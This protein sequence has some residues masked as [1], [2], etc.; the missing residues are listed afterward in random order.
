MIPPPC[1]NEFL[2][3]CHIELFLKLPDFIQFLLGVMNHVAG[4][5]DLI[6]IYHHSCIITLAAT[7]TKFRV[8]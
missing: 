5:I 6:I 8:Y 7:N 4:C 1:S 2:K 3:Y